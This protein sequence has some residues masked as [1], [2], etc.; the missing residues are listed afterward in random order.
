MSTAFSQNFSEILRN[1][2]KKNVKISRKI[3]KIY[4]LQR[5][6]ASLSG[7]MQNFQNFAQNLESQRT[8]Y[9]RSRKILKNEALIVK[10]SWF[11]AGI[12]CATVPAFQPSSALAPK[13][14]TVAAAA[15][16]AA[17][18]MNLRR[19]RSLR[20]FDPTSSTS[21][22][23]HQSRSVNMDRMSAG[24]KR[25]PL[26]RTSGR[27]CPWNLRQSCGHP[28]PGIRGLAMRDSA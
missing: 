21:P 27:Q 13:R 4:S 28:L 1:S 23:I 16:T 18:L 8:K 20:L 10:R 22:L 24:D 12:R 9:Y 26:R 5:N 15:A 17:V 19:V 7:I 6:F 14:G 2:E 11:A 3:S 25:K